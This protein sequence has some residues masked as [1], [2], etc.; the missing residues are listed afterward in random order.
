MGTQAFLFPHTCLTCRKVPNSMNRSG[1]KPEGAGVGASIVLMSFP[2]GVRSHQQT[3]GLA[4]TRPC[5]RWERF[6]PSFKHRAPSSISRNRRFS[7]QQARL[8]YAAGTPSPQTVQGGFPGVRP[9][10]RETSTILSPSFS[11][12]SII[13]CHCFNSGQQQV[14]KNRHS[15]LTNF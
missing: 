8:H 12:F 1:R 14:S 11:N 4:H 6:A 3:P 13:S 7:Q 5:P 2:V 10:P 9:F 15:K